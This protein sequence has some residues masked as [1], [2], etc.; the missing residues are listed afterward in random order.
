MLIPMIP[1]LVLSNS[2]DGGVEW[3]KATGF[4]L[5][6]KRFHNFYPITTSEALGLILRKYFYNSTDRQHLEVEGYILP[7][8]K[9]NPD[10][11]LMVELLIVHKRNVSNASAEEFVANVLLPNKEKLLKS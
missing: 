4:S 5:R 3:C 11:E 7:D 8:F 2:Y 1:I 10:R 6:D 9:D